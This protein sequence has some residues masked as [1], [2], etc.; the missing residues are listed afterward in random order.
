MKKL[1]VLC[2][3]LLAFALILASGCSVE[4][5]SY[6]GGPNQNEKL[7][8]KP[9]RRASG[10]YIAADKAAGTMEA[11]AIYDYDA[12][13]YGYNYAPSP[14]AE[15]PGGGDYFTFLSNLPPERKIIR[16]AN[17]V[18]EVES[19]ERVYDTILVNV[20][21]FG[22]YEAARDM[23]SGSGNYMAVN[24][25]LKIPS[26]NLDMFL[27]EIKK[28]GAVLTSTVSSSDITDEYFDSQTRLGTLEKTLAKYY[29]FLEN[30][31]D[32]DEQL[33]VARYISDITN[34]I[35]QIKGRV[36]RWDSLVDYSTVTL[37]LYRPADPEPE[38]TTEPA[39][40]PET[41]ERVVEWSAISGDD[42]SFNIM[43]GI[44]DTC[45][46]ILRIFQNLVTWL[47][48][49]SPVLIPLAVV[50]FLII[51]YARKKIRE[52]KNNKKSGDNNDN[53]N[54]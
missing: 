29:E 5:D 51:R 36:K 8:E 50:L 3:A 39:T 28:E 18:M 44:A 21:K 22:G 11:G 32:V 42:M 41:T 25:T 53:G 1:F 2:A 34:E 52:K 7:E 23:R 46:A 20:A 27:N 40:E 19:A 6:D 47:I 12:E 9:A 48:T 24:A 43:Q 16:D 37:Y 31:K 38:E 45:S 17:L 15:A 54:I 26:N 30:A 35:E 13:S 33:K 4:Y 14:A 49:A 10:D